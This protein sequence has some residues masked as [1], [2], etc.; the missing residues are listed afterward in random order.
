MATDTRVDWRFRGRWV[1]ANSLGYALG[2]FAG[3]ALGHVVL[4]NVA[5]GV[6]IGAVVGG[7]QM[8][9]LRRR[10]SVDARWIACDV[11]GLGVAL[12]GLGLFSFVSGYPFNL[13]WPH[14]AIGWGVAFALGGGL[15]A[16]LQAG[17][18]PGLVRRSPWVVASAAGWGLS[19]LVLAIPAD[20]SSSMPVVLVLLRNGLM[21]PAIAGLVLGLATMAALSPGANSARQR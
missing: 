14:G 19:A 3:F 8:R 20:M 15:S 6:G 9:T 18:A 16:L 17:V 12:A 4:G 7:L 5:I 10:A 2:F 11:V 13:G 1:A 21:A